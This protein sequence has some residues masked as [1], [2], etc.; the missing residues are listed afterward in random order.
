[1]AEFLNAGSSPYYEE[2]FLS[3]E[4]STAY[5][6]PPSLNGKKKAQIKMD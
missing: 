4:P 5:S 1:M 2:N 6:T 3:S